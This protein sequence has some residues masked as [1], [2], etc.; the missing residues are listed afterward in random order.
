TL[1]LLLSFFCLSTAQSQSND[2]ET[3]RAQFK[4][5]KNFPKIQS[6]TS[7]LVCIADGKEEPILHMNNE[8]IMVFTTLNS[9]KQNLGSIQKIDRRNERQHSV[10]TILK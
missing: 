10:P 7:D 3:I 4:Q 6:E 5:M 8:N 2:F 1:I 9:Q